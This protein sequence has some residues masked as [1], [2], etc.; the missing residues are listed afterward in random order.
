MFGDVVAKD[1]VDFIEFCFE[2]FEGEEDLEGANENLNRGKTR[3][4]K[5]LKSSCNSCLIQLFHSLH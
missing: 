3:K 5:N 4:E 1:G 2:D